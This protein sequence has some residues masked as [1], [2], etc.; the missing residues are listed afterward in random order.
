MVRPRCRR[1][2]PGRRDATAESTKPLRLP[3]R[4]ALTAACLI[5][6]SAAAVAD[7]TILNVSYDVSRELYKDVNPAFIADW[8]AKAGETVAVNQSHG[9]SSKQAMS[10]ASGL[11]AD[12]ITM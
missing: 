11:E 4:A 5:L 8:K 6:A 1:P 2:Y 10:V 9:G 3:A 7:I 12:V